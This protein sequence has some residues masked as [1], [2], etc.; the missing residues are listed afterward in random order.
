MAVRYLSLFSGIEA[1]TVAWQPLGWE[2][3]AFSEI[4]PFPCAVLAH[5]YP[6]IPNLGDINKITEDDI[7][8]LGAIDVVVF[9]SPCQDLS[10]AGKREGFKNGETRSG[11]FYKAVQIIEWCRKHSGTRFALWENVVGAFYS[12]QGR[13]FSE[14]IRAFTGCQ[15]SVPKEGWQNSGIAYSAEQSLLEWRTLDAKYFGVPQQRRRVFALADFGDWTCRS[16]IL[17]QQA[18]NEFYLS[19]YEKDEKEATFEC[20]ESSRKGLSRSYAGCITSHTEKDLITVTNNQVIVCDEN[21]FPKEDGEYLRAFSVVEKER[22][23]GFPDNYTRIPYRNK[24]AKNCVIHARLK[25]IGNS[26]AVPQLKW[27]GQQM[28]QAFLI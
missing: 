13:D 27:I 21:G 7:K 12:N 5:H 1:A 10:L 9:G 18:N 16:S 11:L 25:A 17:F 23:F 20:R 24:P 14:V 19:T 2:A 8:R 22:M 26:I 3:V 6:S 15:Y 28:Q 4:E